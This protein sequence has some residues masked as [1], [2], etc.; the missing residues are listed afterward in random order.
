[1][2]GNIPEEIIS[3]IMLYNSHPIA[4]ILSGSCQLR[5]RK[6]LVEYFSN[7]CVECGCKLKLS[8]SYMR[9]FECIGMRDKKENELKIYMTIHEKTSREK[10]LAFS[11]PKD[12][13]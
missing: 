12:W 6:T 11:S 3:K 8:Y 13:L 10:F 2:T 9:C 5:N 4:D 1:M 7:D